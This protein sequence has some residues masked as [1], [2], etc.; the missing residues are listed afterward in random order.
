MYCLLIDRETDMP[1][2]GSDNPNNPIGRREL[3]A[4]MRRYPVEPVAASQRH[5]LVK[6][7]PKLPKRGFT[8]PL[9]HGSTKAMAIWARNRARSKSVPNDG[10]TAGRRAPRSDV[11]GPTG[12]LHT[13]TPPSGSA[14]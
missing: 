11:Q 7:L 4:K 1:Y 8:K 5:A 14:T 9:G 10:V 12:R 13:V 6:Q 3:R 2:R